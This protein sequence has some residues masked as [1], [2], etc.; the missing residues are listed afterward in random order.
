MR[1]AQCVAA[2]ERSKDE[3][4]AELV[5]ATCVLGQIEDVLNDDAGNDMIL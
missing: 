1:L 2:Q 5:V 3:T 4:E